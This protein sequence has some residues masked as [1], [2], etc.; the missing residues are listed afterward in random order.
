MHAQTFLFLFALVFF[1]NAQS[2]GEDNKKVGSADNDSKLIESFIQ[3]RGYSNTIVFDASNVKR[4]WIDKS[5]VSRDASINIVLDKGSSYDWTGIPL[6]VQLA[7]VREDLDCRIDVISK[8]QDFDFSVLNKEKELI[9]CSPSNEMFI[10]HKI[11]SKSFHLED[12]TS[13]LFHLSFNSRQLTTLSIEKIVFSFSTNKKSNFLYGPGSITI[14]K[15]DLI[16]TV[17]KPKIDGND[18]VFSVTGKTSSVISKNKI[19]VQDNTLTY[20]VKINNVGKAPVT[21]YAGLAPFTQDMDLI[22]DRNMPYNNTN[23]II[24]VVSSELGSN[25]I[26]VDS[27]PEWEKNCVLALNAKEDLSDFPNTNYLG[28]ITDVRKKD[29]GQAEIVLSQPLKTQIERGT[30]A[31]IQGRQ[32]GKYLFFNIKR[33]NGASTFYYNLAPGEE[34]VITSSIKKDDDFFQFS[35]KALCRGVYCVSPALYFFLPVDFNEEYEVEIS[36]Y[37]VNY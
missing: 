28:N 22:D 27:Y 37:V 25:T 34:V 2:N 20:S 3:S 7:N 5:I 30:S 10:D 17:G 19:I 16:A 29:N 8:D 14:A 26:V 23:K 9:Q 1:I 21:V 36:D 12:T 4:F 35:E 32:K 6:P 11:T 24:S 13:F 18:K 33:A 15:D 31:R